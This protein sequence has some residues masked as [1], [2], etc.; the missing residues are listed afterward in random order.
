MK[1]NAAPILL[2]SARIESVAHDGAINSLTAELYEWPA[3]V[4]IYGGRR[5]V[6]ATFRR[7]HVIV[8]GGDSPADS[9]YGREIMARVAA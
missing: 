8:G 4:P 9:K 2:S 3:G 7:N 5:Y 1:N 6:R